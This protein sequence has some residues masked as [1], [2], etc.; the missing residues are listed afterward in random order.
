MAEK[1][2][3]IDELLG[4]RTN[5]D[6]DSAKEFDRMYEIDMSRDG[7]LEEKLKIALAGILTPT[8]YTRNYNTDQI[9]DGIYAALIDWQWVLKEEYIAA[10]KRNPTGNERILFNKVTT[11]LRRILTDVVVCL[12]K[13]KITGQEAAEAIQNI[14]PIYTLITRHLPKTDQATTQNAYQPDA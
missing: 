8:T 4:Q 7:R 14:R 2:R 1:L 3:G 10:R 11:P 5:I 13:G 6:E 12:K 9:Q